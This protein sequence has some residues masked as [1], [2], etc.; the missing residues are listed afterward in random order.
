MSRR[1]TDRDRKGVLVPFRPKQAAHVPAAEELS[2]EALVAACAVNDSAALGVLF[3]RYCQN[4]ARFLSRLV[5]APAPDI[6][7]LIQSTFVQAWRGSS[8]YKAKGSVRS[9]LYGI[10]ANLARHYIRGEV[11]RRKAIAGLRDEP[12]RNRRSV[13]SEVADAQLVQRLTDVL[14]QLTHDQRVAFVLCDIEE[15]SGVEAA[16]ALGIRQGTM[17]RRLH[18]ARRSLRNLLEGGSR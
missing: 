4:L 11:R 17:W 9:W 5:T 3:D 8:S 16:R 6:E 12:E 1:G 2:D 18:D 7:D 14:Q 13:S 10:A 15:M